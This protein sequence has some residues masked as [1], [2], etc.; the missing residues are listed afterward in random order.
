MPWI[1]WL[2]EAWPWARLAIAG[3]WVVVILVA[4]SLISDDNSNHHAT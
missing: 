1:T 3:L 2:Q 4:R